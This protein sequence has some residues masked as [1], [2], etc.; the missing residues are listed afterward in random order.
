MVKMK[1]VIIGDGVAGQIAVEKLLKSQ[2]KTEIVMITKEEY[3]YYSRIYLPHYIEGT[4]TKEQ[5]LLRN[6]DWYNE[7]DIQMMVKTEIE[8]IDLKEHL[9]R[10]KDSSFTIKYDKLILT[11]GSSPRK[12]PFGNPDV[13]G[14]FTLRTIADAD[15]ILNFMKERNAKNVF[16][17]GGGLLGIELGFHIKQTDQ[18][19]LNVRICEIFPYL[20][21]RQLDEK[22]SDLLKKYLEDKG[23]EFVLGES[24]D[25]VTG[26]EYVDGI[27]LKSGK[28]FSTD[29]VLQQLGIIPNIQVAKN[30]GLKT[31]KGIIV[32]EFMQTSDP[33]VYA[34]GDCI[35]FEN[36]IWG[37]IPA[38]M[39]QAKLAAAHILGENPDPYAPSIWNT[40]LK[41]AG[42]DLTCLGTPK[43]Q[44]EGEANVI[45]NVNEKSYLCRKVIIEGN[46][47]TGA[48]LMGKGADTNYFKKNIGK[49]VELDEVKKKIDE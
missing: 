33:D 20:L 25:K 8:K 46:K 36:Q 47:L 11:T 38:S 13:K 21:P 43:P 26:D 34:A 14:M 15:D 27:V 5:L 23:L 2:D 29:V 12:L 3:P 41:V 45:W 49:K 39:D 35:Q 40:R 48:I 32:N 42:L 16:I 10:I 30:S 17:I 37:I 24:V 31:D 44:H 9:V 6:F 28:K 1:V 18:N 7:H 19:N 22:T 4:K